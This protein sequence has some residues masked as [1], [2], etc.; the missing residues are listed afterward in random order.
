VVFVFVGKSKDLGGHDWHRNN[1]FSPRD[2]V[3]PDGSRFDWTKVTTW[4]SLGFYSTALYGALWAYSGWDKA[5]YVAAELRNPSRQLPLSINTA[6]PTIILCYIAANAVYYILL[7]W[8]VVSTTDAAAVVSFLDLRATTSHTDTHQTAVTQFLG[9]SVAY[10]ATALICLVIAGSALGNSFVAG[11]MTVAAANNNWFPRV[12]GTVGCVGTLKVSKIADSGEPA[13]MT[14]DNG[15]S[16][17]YVHPS[18]LDNHSLTNASNALILN[19]IL[20]GI[21][22]LLGNM[23]ILLTLNGLAEYAFFFLT[24]LGAIILR[25][26]E[27]DLPRPVKP[28]IV[29]PILFALISGF[30]VIRGAVFAPIQAAVLVGIWLCGLVFYFVRVWFLETRSG[31]SD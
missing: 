3:L 19:T 5:N 18:L 15:E 22:I 8:E 17:M 4:Q 7:P 25:F 10:F 6:I 31:R 9:K 16:P 23:R 21:Y 24:V 1:W 27:P 20:S 30:V 28:L 13:D 12:L 11:R 2:T 29:I 26:R 14:M